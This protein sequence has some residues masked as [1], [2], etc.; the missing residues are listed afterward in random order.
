MSQY[1][2]QIGIIAR[3]IVVAKYDVCG[4]HCY[5][6]VNPGGITIEHNVHTFS[7]REY[8]FSSPVQNIYFEKLEIRL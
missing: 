6:L 7:H 1:C 2:P 8:D 3:S 4:A 5:H